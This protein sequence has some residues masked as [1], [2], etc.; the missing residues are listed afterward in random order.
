MSPINSIILWNEIICRIINEIKDK[1][2]YKRG[3]TG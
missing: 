2:Y 3:A 1:S